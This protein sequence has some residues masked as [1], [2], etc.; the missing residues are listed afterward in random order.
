MAKYYKHLLL[1]AYKQGAEF[2]KE[3]THNLRIKAH[4]RTLDHATITSTGIDYFGNY[5]LN[6]FD[7]YEVKELSFFKRIRHSLRV[8]F[9]TVASYIGMGPIQF[10]VGGE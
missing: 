9:T 3:E 7:F 6:I 8:F 5:V 10:I 4:K 1:T 2:T